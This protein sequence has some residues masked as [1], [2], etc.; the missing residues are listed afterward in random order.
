MQFVGRRRSR[1]S[2]LKSVLKCQRAMIQMFST[3]ELHRRDGRTVNE[4][5][6]ESL[7]IL[8]ESHPY[9]HFLNKTSNK[10]SLFKEQTKIPLIDFN[11]SVNDLFKITLPH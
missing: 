4:I 10:T 2:G 11:C 9:R 7:P 5:F 8:Y 3:I 1:E 6:P